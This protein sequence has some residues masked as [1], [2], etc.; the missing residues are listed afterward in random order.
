MVLSLSIPH[1][2]NN[3]LEVNLEISDKIKSKLYEL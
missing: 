2:N 3:N 1:S